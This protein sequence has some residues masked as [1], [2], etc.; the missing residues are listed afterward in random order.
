MLCH[1]RLRLKL[2]AY[3]IPGALLNWLTAFVV[4]CAFQVKIGSTFSDVF[5]SDSVSDFL[6]LRDDLDSL[7]GWSHAWQL[8][9]S[10]DRCK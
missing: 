4:V 8:G 2:Q 9:V 6:T 1:R 10:H 3:G 7:S 5:F